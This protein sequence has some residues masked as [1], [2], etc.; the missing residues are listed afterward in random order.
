MRKFFYLLLIPLLIISINTFAQTIRTDVL[1]I[2]G[3]TFGISAAKQAVKS[4]VKA[5][6]IE[7]TGSL[8]NTYEGKKVVT[9]TSR[10]DSLK[11]SLDTLKNLKIVLKVGVKSKERDGNKWK[12]RLTDGTKIS[13]RAI[14]DAE[15]RK[16]LAGK[17]S[18]YD[19]LV[20]NTSSTWPGNIYRTF[21]GDQPIKFFVDG[22]EE[23]F[24]SLKSIGRDA[25]GQAAGAIAAYCAFFETTAKKLDVRVIQGEILGYKGHLVDIYDVPKADS[26]YLPIQRIAVTGIIELININGGSDLFQP[27]EK[28]KI[29]DITALREYFTRSKLWFEDNPLGEL[30]LE[31]LLSLIKFTGNRG[32]E[33]NREVEKGWKTSFKFTDS[34]DLKKQ[35]TRRQAAVLIDAYLKPFNTKI[36]LD[37]RIM[38]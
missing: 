3:N 31:K 17:D 15:P 33:L 18:I 4:G 25:N 9:N 30:T 21:V 36:N 22:K 26:N 14:V 32:E 5:H 10:S 24:I 38:N 12:V 23:N 6:L 20:G 34:F 29:Q 1:V 19:V 11:K 28:V 37:G 35:L 7:E 2:G 16:F 13:A 8:G 27:N